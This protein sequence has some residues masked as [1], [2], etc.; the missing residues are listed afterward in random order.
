MIAYMK[1]GLRLINSIH[2]KSLLNKKLKLK[3][4]VFKARNTMCR[5][6]DGTQAKPPSSVWPWPTQPSWKNTTV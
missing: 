3:T 2:L 5:I 6:R 1:Q 4:E